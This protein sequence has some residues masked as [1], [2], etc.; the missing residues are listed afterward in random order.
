M[1]PALLAS[2]SVPRVG[3]G[4]ARTRP[5]ALLADKA[6]SA[7]AH[8]AHL[9]TRKIT[10]V[11]PEKTDQ[12][13]HRRERGSA[14]GRPVNFDAQTYKNR[15]VVERGFNRI[16][17]WRGLATRYDKHAVVYRGGVVLAAIMLWLE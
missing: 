1:L 9:R 15:N 17:Q 5:D 13:R 6:Y 16:K 14:G 12:V 4:R 8:R 10:V 3:P 11:I 7:R 2:L